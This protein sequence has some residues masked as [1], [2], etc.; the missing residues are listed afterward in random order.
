MSH[1]LFELISGMVFLLIAAG[2][3]ARILLKVRV[4][5]EIGA[6]RTLIPMWPSVLAAIATAYLAVQ[7]F[8]LARSAIRN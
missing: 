6:E 2:H 4:A 5:L 1:R 8:R 3:L 7:A